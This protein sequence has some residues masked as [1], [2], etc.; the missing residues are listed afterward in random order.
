MNDARFVERLLVFFGFNLIFIKK[1]ITQALVKH[2][3]RHDTSRPTVTFFSVEIVHHAVFTSINGQYMQQVV[4]KKPT[5]YARYQYRFKIFG[6]C[7]C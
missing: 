7:F 1:T 5:I 6:L 3:R 2:H 4:I